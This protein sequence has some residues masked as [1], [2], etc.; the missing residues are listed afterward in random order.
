VTELRFPKDFVFG[1]ATSAHQVE[2]GNEFNDW[3]EWETRGKVPRSGRACGHWHMY[4]EDIELMARLGYRGYRF[5]VEWSRIYPRADEVNE[6]ALMRYAEIVDLLRGH[7]IEP[8]VTLHH[9]TNPVWFNEK[10]GWLREDNIGFF[11]KFVEAVANALKGVKYWVVFNEPNVYV[12]QG[13]I[14]GV[15]PPGHRGISKG[16]RAMENLI[17][18]HAEAYKILRK[19]G[20]MVGVAQNLIAFK[21]AS[22]RRLDVGKARLVDLAY[23]WGFIDGVLNG[24]YVFFRGRSRAVASDLNF[25]GVNYYSSYIVRHSWNPFK[26][27]VDVKPLE[28][29]TKTTMGYYMYPRGIY[30]VV[31]AAYERTQRT[32]I[33]TENGFAVEDDED[34]IR[35]II[36]H[37]QYLHKAMSEGV[38]VRGY[39][40]WSFMDNYE[41]DKGFEQRFG[42]IEVD[43]ETLK[44]RPR[45]SAYVYGRI[46][47]TN[48]IPG[49]L[50]E[51]YGLKSLE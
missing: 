24:E 25:I 16:K 41:W 50:L 48:T 39:Y 7:G 26:L 49:D 9:F 14:L 44:R 27:F 3:W 29:G 42:L 36:R 35:G 38:R 19:R 30:E 6:G 21:P 2:G 51:K 46:A 10:G 17:K 1:T 32:I 37:L 34:R 13:F 28:A 45:K 22:S 40:Y 8:I 5:S 20:V 4:W 47:R 23:N 33:I 31:K 15:W 43:Y 11:L 18:A 12:L